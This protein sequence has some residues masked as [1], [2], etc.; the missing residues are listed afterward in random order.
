MPAYLF[1]RRAFA[2]AVSV[3]VIDFSIR[4]SSGIVG[5]GRAGYIVWE[6]L[7]PGVCGA[8]SPLR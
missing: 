3:G 6:R 5:I 7:Q 1:Q 4:M 8:C 2:E